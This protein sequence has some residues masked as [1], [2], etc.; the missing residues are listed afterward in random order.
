M[1]S[2]EGTPGGGDNGSVDQTSTAPVKKRFLNGWT[3]ELEDLIADWADK[4]ACYRW[5]HEKTN[6][7]F[8]VRDR[9]FNIPVIILSGVTAGANFA[10]GSIFDETQVEEKKWAQL[11]LGGASLIAGIIQTLMNFYRYA[12]LSE[13]HR[14]SGISWGKFNRLLCIEMSLHPDERMDAFNFLKLFR[15]E[16]DRLIEQSPSIPD[17][18]IKDFNTIFQNVNVVKPEIVGILNH[19]KVY[20]DTGARLKRIAAE[21]TIALHFKRGVIKQLVVDDIQTKMVRAATEAARSSAQAFFEEQR[22]AALEIAKANVAAAARKFEPK[23]TVPSIIARRQEE[24]KQE[25]NTIAVQ[26][27]GA[28][29][30]LKERFKNA[31][32]TANPTANPTANTIIPLKAL[33]NTTDNKQQSGNIQ[34][35]QSVS[36]AVDTVAP[37]ID[38][39][40]NVV[41]EGV[42]E[43][44][45]TPT[46]D[47]Y[48][49]ASQNQPQDRFTVS[50]N[51]IVPLNGTATATTAVTTAGTNTID[52][53]EMIQVSVLDT[54][55]EDEVAQNFSTPNGE[56]Q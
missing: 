1:S 18:I 45:G 35:Q 14:V 48:L 36:F 5:M 7:I 21:A 20:K 41:G 22:N 16:L 27:A 12:Q 30:E 10:L 56:T 33:P 40:V 42:G 51:T 24:Q 6:G 9:Y 47:K 29:A 2:G 8:A 44:V 39:A 38:T 50:A 55:S 49:A 3:S 32:A 34:P 31:N 4:A 25:L 53:S 46:T 37:N 19:T 43:G 26:R 28:V 23:P 13:A 15:V 52:E 17:L 11:G 54:D